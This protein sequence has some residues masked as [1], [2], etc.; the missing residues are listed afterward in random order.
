M[1]NIKMNGS[2]TEIFGEV[3]IFR[4]FQTVKNPFSQ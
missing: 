3:P 1:A 4:G 2:L